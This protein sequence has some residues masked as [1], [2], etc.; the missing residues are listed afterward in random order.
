MVSAIAQPDLEAV[1]EELPHLPEVFGPITPGLMTR[2]RR[3]SSFSR[4]RLRAH[5]AAVIVP[6]LQGDGREAAGGAH[7]VVWQQPLSALVRSFPAP[8]LLTLDYSERSAWTVLIRAARTAGTNDAKIAEATMTAADP[9]NGS[10]PGSW[11][12]ET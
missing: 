4:G 5:F 1:A 10:S 7:G 8:S 6:L 11:S 2:R 9:I 3:V 12:A